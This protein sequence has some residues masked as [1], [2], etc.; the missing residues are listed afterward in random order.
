MCLPHHLSFKT[1]RL[2]E[3]GQVSLGRNLDS[4]SGASPVF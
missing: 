3:V 4:T 1:T 2:K